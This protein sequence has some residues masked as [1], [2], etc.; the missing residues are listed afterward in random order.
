LPLSVY[1]NDARF[2]FENAIKVAVEASDNGIAEVMI[3][4]NDAVLRG[5]RSLKVSESKFHAFD[6]PAFPPIGEIT[7]T[8]VHF[9][10]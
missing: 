4:F 5:N 7:S 6:S 1:G 8:G 3:S 10:H 9:R 2:N